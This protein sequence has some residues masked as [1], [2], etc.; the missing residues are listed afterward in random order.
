M[1][2]PN[3]CASITIDADPATIFAILTDPRQH[4]RID[5]SGTVKGAVSGDTELRLGS[6]FR[7]DMNMGAPYK[8]NNKVVEY[9]PDSLI[10]W[11]HMGLHRWR[12]E[13]VP[14]GAG[15]AQTT[16]TE[17]WDVSAYPRVVAKLFSRAFGSRTQKSIEQTLDRLKDAAESDAR[18]AA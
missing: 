1:T 14:A 6:E 16:V 18:A 8:I 7:M 9:E 10:A 13:L 3:A 17:T 11:R 15:G 2:D 5:G 4:A 12:Y